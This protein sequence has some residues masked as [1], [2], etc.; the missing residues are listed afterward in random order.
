MTFLSFLA[1]TLLGAPDSLELAAMYARAFDTLAT[2]PATA[3]FLGVAGREVYHITSIAD[4]LFTIDRY[5][6]DGDSFGETVSVYG[7]VNLRPIHSFPAP[8]LGRLTSPTEPKGVLFFST[9]ERGE[10]IAELF[11]YH[12]EYLSYEEYCTSVD[13]L[14]FLLRI[15]SDGH[16]SIRYRVRLLR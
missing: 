7:A 4:S 6:F 1:L 15:G 9:L 8:W 2:E 12:E 5:P 3:S 14:K 16:P 10:I 11:A 13:G